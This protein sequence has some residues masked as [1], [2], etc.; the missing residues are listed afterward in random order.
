MNLF[1]DQGMASEMVYHPYQLMVKVPDAIHDKTVVVAVVEMLYY[2]HNM[3]NLIVQALMVWLG[4]VEVL[5]HLKLIE[6][7]F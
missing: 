5:F 7:S 3:V 2:D 1:P 6:I 4:M